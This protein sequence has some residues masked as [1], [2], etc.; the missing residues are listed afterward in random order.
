MRG[1]LFISSV[2]LLLMAMVIGACSDDASNKPDVPFVRLVKD[3]TLQST[4]LSRA[5]K[6][7]VFL[8]EGY[9]ESNESY[10]VVYLLHGYG[11][12]ETSWYTNGGLQY[13][14]DLYAGETVPMI[15][16]MPEANNTY[17]INRYNGNY[18][19][20]EMFVNELVPE[21]DRKFRT[22]ADKSQRAV[23][24]YSMG[25]YGAL[26]LP[27]LNPNVF[28]VSIPLSMSFRTDAQY[29]AETQGSFDVQW[30]PNFG[31]N[32]GASGAE[33]LTNYFKVHSP[34][35]F[36]NEPVGANNTVK[37]LIDCGDDEES[38][39][40]T[41]NSLHGIMRDKDIEHEYRV[42]SG[43]HSFDYWKQS[44]REALQFI[45]NAVQGIQHP[46]QPTPATVGTLITADQ[47][48]EVEIDN[49]V[50]NVMLPTDYATSTASYPVLY[51]IHDA[52]SGN[53]SER[54]IQTLSMLRNAMTSTRLP[55]SIVVEIP[56]GSYVTDGF[57]TNVVAMIDNEY[58]TKNEAENRVVMANAAAGQTAVDVV[59]TTTGLFGD[60]FLYNARFNDT[61]LP[62]SLNVFY[63]LDV[64]DDATS[65]NQYHNLF[66]TIR[67]QYIGYE[68][69]V[70]Q[71]TETFQ[72][73]LNGL[74]NS[75][76]VM[77][78]SLNN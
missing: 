1:R 3:Q 52:E 45:S 37:Y 25:G 40:F 39:I 76:T 54:S 8:P 31:P 68:Y 33:R 11:D 61:T 65:Y 17:Y 10:P 36:F 66:T 32:K 6:Y 21:I 70:R 24:G 69:R 27:A 13:Y 48:S 56:A 30:A 62:V 78:P 77:T 22:K 57:M 49:H 51:F 59:A 16:I 67:N 18:P 35:H 72:D 63:Y 73:F 4:I 64:T 29:M 28:S 34:F 23:M 47:V 12:N 58:R 38:L 7:S 2:V 19:Y 41:S 55:K 71:G 42:R 75:F 9:R 15:Y 20:M 50:V 53:V 5:I 74:Y 43:G 60:C 14:V 46:S 44:Y 26:I